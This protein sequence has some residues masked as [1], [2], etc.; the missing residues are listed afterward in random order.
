M[1]AGRAVIGGG[2]TGHSWV[3]D[4]RGHVFHRRG[5]WRRYQI[6]INIDSQAAA[7]EGLEVLRTD[8]PN[9]ATPGKMRV[10][11]VF[12]ATGLNLSRPTGCATGATEPCAGHSPVNGGCW[13]SLYIF[14]DLALVPGP[15]SILAL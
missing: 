1:S 3:R 4:S 7:N 8:R 10:G 12:T 11:Q 9:R 15:G 14:P 5:D 13:L 2:G 6:E